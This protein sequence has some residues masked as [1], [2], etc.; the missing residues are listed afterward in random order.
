MPLSYTCCFIA[1]LILQSVPTEKKKK[2]FLTHTSGKKKSRSRAEQNRE[3]TGLLQ[4][5]NSS[6][7]KTVSVS[8]V[9]IFPHLTLGSAKP[10]T[11]GLSYK[12]T[13]GVN[14]YIAS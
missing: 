3:L 11:T 12:S 5:A 10:P 6:T 7:I 1:V 9:V 2:V 8:R 14:V 4:I 13:I